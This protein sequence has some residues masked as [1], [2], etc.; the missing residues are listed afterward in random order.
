MGLWEWTGQGGVIGPAPAPR[1]RLVAV[2]EA[3]VLPGDLRQEYDMMMAM[4][5]TGSTHI[6]RIVYAPDQP[7]VLQAAAAVAANGVL[8]FNTLARLYLE[9]YEQGDLQKILDLRISKS[10]PYSSIY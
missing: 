9:Y 1:N 10:V 6:P 7:T 2:K 8:P 3:A 4:Q 5:T